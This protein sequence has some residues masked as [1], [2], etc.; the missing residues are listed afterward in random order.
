MGEWGGERFPRGEFWI[1]MGSL[2]QVQRLEMK[3]VLLFRV[4][5][6]KVVGHLLMDR[7][8]LF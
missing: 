3:V 5:I 6:L 4:D 1:V 2:T 8:S 7:E